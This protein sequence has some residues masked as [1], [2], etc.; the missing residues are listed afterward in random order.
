MV[1]IVL[2]SKG[3]LYMD[4]GLWHNFSILFKFRQMNSSTKELAASTAEGVKIR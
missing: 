4:P 1:L 3:N 2:L